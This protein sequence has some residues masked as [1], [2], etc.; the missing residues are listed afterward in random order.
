VAAAPRSSSPP[1]TRFIDLNTVPLAPRIGSY[2]AEMLYFG[3][4]GQRYWRNWLHVHSFYEICLCYGGRGTFLNTDTLHNI[5]AGHVFIAK[6]GQSHEIVSERSQP[7]KIY[8]WAFALRRAEAAG[9]ALEIDR[10]IES[11]ER[12]D[13]QVQTDDGAMLDTC[14]LLTGEIVARRPGYLTA[15]EG[16]VAKLVLDTARS[17]AD[18]SLTSERVEPPAHSPNEAVV[19]RVKTYL[20]D[21]LSRPVALRDVAAQ[22]HLSERHL[23]RIFREQTGTTPLDFLTTLRLETAQQMLLNQDKTIKEVA[24]ACGYPDVHYFTTLFGKR[25]GITPAAFR[26]QGGTRFLRP[27]RHHEG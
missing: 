10:L 24:R 15:I 2:V 17:V 16:L 6:P 4:L 9:S 18:A 21:N 20:R 14:R 25:L 3:H 27:R 23:A 22:V 11:F 5:R 8:F 7:V 26:E 1:P 12:S 13:T 19:N